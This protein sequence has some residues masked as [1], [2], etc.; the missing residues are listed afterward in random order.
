MSP[1]PPP[2]SELASGVELEAARWRFIPADRLGAGATSDVW[3]ARDLDT[4]R[5]VA[6]KVARSADDA[7]W[8]VPEAERLACGLSPHLPQLIPVGRVP[9][10]PPPQLVPG[11]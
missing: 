7:A 11:A 6:L 9:P 4:G 10:G 3:R 1:E 5:Y 8:L 2:P